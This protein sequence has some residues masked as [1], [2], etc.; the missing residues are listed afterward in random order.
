MVERVEVEPP[1]EVIGVGIS[2]DE[3]G[4]RKEFGQRCRL[5]QRE[6]ERNREK[7]NQKFTR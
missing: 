5:L 3:G 1:T 2:H 4:R 7:G 6:G